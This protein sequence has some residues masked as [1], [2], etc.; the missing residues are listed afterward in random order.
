MIALRQAP[1]VALARAETVRRREAEAARA[2]D[3]AACRG[4]L[5]D[6]EH[7]STEQVDSINLLSL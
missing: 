5:I 6:R 2:E 7:A 3:G 4:R 1:E